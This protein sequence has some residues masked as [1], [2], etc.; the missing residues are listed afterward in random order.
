MSGSPGHPRHVPARVI[1]ASQSPRRR[2][3][4]ALIGVLHE[5]RPAH[6]DESYRR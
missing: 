1:L 3:L 2:E 4:L 6:I 5:V